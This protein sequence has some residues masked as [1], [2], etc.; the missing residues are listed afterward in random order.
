M[1]ERRAAVMRGVLCTNMHAG[2]LPRIAPIRPS[3]QAAQT[4]PHLISRFRSD[5][6]GYFRSPTPPSLRSA[7]SHAGDGVD[8][9]KRQRSVIHA[10]G[11][12]AGCVGTPRRTGGRASRWLTGLD[13]SQVG[14]LG[15]DRH[16]QD[17]RQGGGGGAGPGCCSAALLQLS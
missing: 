8:W 5:T 3:K 6:R 9:R 1:S 13:P 7:G 4:G 12:V 15:V 2:A 16:T 14:E 17:L 10:S 11:G